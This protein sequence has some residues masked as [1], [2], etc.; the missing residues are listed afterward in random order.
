M[1]VVSGRMARADGV[2]ISLER[3]GVPGAGRSSGSAGGGSWLAHRSRI[4]LGVRDACLEH[5]LCTA[6]VVAITRLLDRRTQ[7]RCLSASAEHSKN[8]QGLGGPHG[9]LLRLAVAKHSVIVDSDVVVG[10]RSRHRA[11]VLGRRPQGPDSRRCHQRAAPCPL[12]R[13]LAASSARRSAPSELFQPYV[14]HMSQ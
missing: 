13:V 14:T 4:M 1:H 7:A 9:G 8:R 2:Y 11:D 10:R 12:A 6:V 5:A 3:P